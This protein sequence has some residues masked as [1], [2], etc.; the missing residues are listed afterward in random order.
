MDPAVKKQ[1]LRLF[2]YGLY[3]VSCA[4]GDEVNAFTANWLTQVSFE[5]PLV[6]VSIEKD[7]KSL[8]MIQRSQKFAINVLRTGQR[9]LA[10]ML[11]KSGFKYPDK[12]Q[13]ISHELR[14]DGYVVL[15]DAL[16]WVGCEVR[17]SM[18]AGDSILV[19]AEVVDV[20]LIAEGQPLSMAEAGFRHAG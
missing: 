10:G 11:G 7:A 16:G 4:E 3:A 19:L 20:G 14:P 13:G 5:P 6:A 1:V 15:H 18:D 9:E 2:M 12:L 8:P 17:N